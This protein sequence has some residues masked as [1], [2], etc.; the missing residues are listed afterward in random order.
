LA[1]TPED[2]EVRTCLAQALLYSGCLAGDAG[3]LEAALS[4]LEQA[5]AIYLAFEPSDL[6]Y[7]CRTQLYNALQGLAD[8]FGQ[9]GRASEQERSRRLCQQILQHLLGSDLASSTDASSLGLETLGRLFQRGDFKEM[10]AHK[11]RPIRDHHE[12]VVAEWLALSVGSLSPFRSSSS[13]ATYDR[14]PEA[15]AVALIS[16]IRD[17]CSKLGLADSMVPAA[18]NVVREEAYEAASG[19]RRLGRLADA[20]SIAARLMVLARRLVREYPDSALSYRVLSD[21]HDQ[22]KKN[23]I[24]ADD[25]SLMEAALALAIEAAQRALALDPDRLETRSHFEKLTGQLASIQAERKAAG[26][27]QP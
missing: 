15:G 18:I 11:D 1:K 5:V 2:K 24:D 27:S 9:S 3:Q 7:N 16:A 23:A 13:A 26:A 20:R 14:D 10:S 4:H 6:D 22:I 25:D 19:K 8:R 17:R 21:A 12:R